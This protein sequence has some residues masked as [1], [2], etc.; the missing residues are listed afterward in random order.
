MKQID[1]EA[2]IGLDLTCKIFGLL[3]STNV[4]EKFNPVHYSNNATYYNHSSWLRS[5]LVASLPCTSAQICQDIF[6]TLFQKRHFG[7][8]RLIRT[9]LSSLL[10]QITDQIPDVVN[11]TKFS[12]NAR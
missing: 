3:A 4:G 6:E 5:N 1:V 10:F 11:S 7:F 8:W 2:V 9:D 12:E